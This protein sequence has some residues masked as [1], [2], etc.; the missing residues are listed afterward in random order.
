VIINNSVSLLTAALLLAGCVGFGGGGYCHI[1]RSQTEAAIQ[2]LSKVQAE[3]DS[4]DVTYSDCWPL[5]HDGTLMK[6]GDDC[7][8]KLLPKSKDPTSGILDGEVAVNFEIPSMT[9]SG[10]SN[11]VY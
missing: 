9:I 3:L 4:D 8:C 1:D 6:S 2:N 11:I 10:V 5:T 7:W